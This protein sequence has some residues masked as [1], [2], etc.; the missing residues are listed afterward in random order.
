M[1]DREYA[2][3]GVYKV[4]IRAPIETVW[5]ELVKTS[6]PRPF[7]WNSG[8]DT[9]GM[10]PG[11]AYRMLSGDGKTVAVVGDIVEIDPPHRLVTSFRLTAYDDPPSRVTYMLEETADGTEFVLITERVAAGSKS[12][13]SMADGSKFIVDNLKAFIE[14]GNVRLGARFM[15]AMYRLMAPLTPKGMRAENWPLEK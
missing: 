10:A 8:W 6:S 9:K 5:A 7:F 3:R 14:T 11:N 15:L 4:L 1:N 13:K 2:E 12:E